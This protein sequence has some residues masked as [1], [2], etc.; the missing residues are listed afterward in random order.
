MLKRVLQ[1]WRF[2]RA[3][4]TLTI[5][6]MCLY[7]Y[8]DSVAKPVYLYAS[9]PGRVTFDQDREGGNPFASALIELLARRSITF[10][11][12]QTDLITLTRQKSRGLQDPDV[13]GGDRLATWRLSPKPQ[14]EKRVALVL[15]FSEY[16]ALRNS[17]PGAKRDM[18]R[19]AGAL[20]KA[21]FDVQAVSDPDQ[22]MLGKIVRSFSELTTRSDVAVLYT[23]GHGVEV[24]GAI[25][26]LP[27]YSRSYLDR[28]IELSMLASKLRARRVNLVFYGGC[29]NGPV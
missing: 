9:Q 27:G 7:L 18:H 13:V 25:Y 10:A 12:F 21:G 26:L 28:A 11:T 22:A 5:V 24:N 20:R 1:I 14:T 29:R 19:V 8:A 23:T 4:Y 16:S 6:L 17:L 2:V 15:V 3:G